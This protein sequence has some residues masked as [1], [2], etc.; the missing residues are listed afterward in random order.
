M[1][2]RVA[3]IAGA[4]AVAVMALMAIASVPSASAAEYV[5]CR[6]VKKGFYSDSKCSVRDE[7]KGKPKGTWEL[8]VVEACEAV[9]K[10][11]YSD[12]GCTVRDEKKGKPKG[13]FEKASGRK[14][15]SHGAGATLGEVY[16]Y[17]PVTCTSYT[18]TGE[19]T[20]AKTGTAQLKFTGCEA[21]GQPCES[22]VGAGTIESTALDT[23]LVE[24]KAGEVLTQF[25]SSSGPSGY[26]YLLYC[27][28]GVDVRVAGKVGGVTTG[29]IN[30]LSPTNTEEFESG[31]GEQGLLTELNFGYGWG[32][33][34]ATRY[35]LT[36]TTTFESETEIKT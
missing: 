13:K 14:F 5:S 24:P 25:V 11:F 4:C 2:F 21:A 23:N 33:P 1:R 27:Y 29:D 36:S 18:N 12:A 15:T 22:G 20:G 10:G 3:R 30:F 17:P 9:K 28:L 26:S 32:G 7:K 35:G 16:G 31:K 34:F 8:K 19:I 6:A